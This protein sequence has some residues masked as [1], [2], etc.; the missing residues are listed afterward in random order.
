MGR[1]PRHLPPNKPPEHAVPPAD[2]VLRTLG[3][4]LTPLVRL[5]LASGLDYTRLV[6][7]L[8]PLFIEQA[9]LELKRGGQ[10]DTNSAIS[11]L[12]GVHRKDVRE[13]RENGLGVRIAQGVSMSS[14]VFARWVQDPL[15]RDRRKRPKPLLR[16]GGAASFDALARSVTQD[17]H[18]YT[19][20]TELIRLGLVS[21]EK[22]KG[23][24]Y[25]V[26]NR[27]GFIP[28]A[29]SRELLELFAGNLSDHA[30]AAVVNLLGGP[31]RLEQSVFAEGITRKSAEEL[32]EL[33]R[34][35]WSQARSELIAEA[36]RRYT[37]DRHRADAT[38][39]ARIGAYYWEQDC[40][41]DQAA[42]D[43]TQEGAQDETD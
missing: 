8:K 19:V 20:L 1:Q 29:G 28:P 30:S 26:P 23:K 40:R 5:L 14:Q 16:S 24:E 9:R 15:Y 37:A 3:S 18:P 33:A 39:R 42:G 11:L 13:W 4:V 21:I 27:D 12:S 7:E 35:F 36:S 25:V 22:R 38:Y 2:E 17:V 41:S 31:P 10:A 34:K 6:A 43:L 32:G